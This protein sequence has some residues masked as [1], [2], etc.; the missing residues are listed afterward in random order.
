M[1]AASPAAPLSASTPWTRPRRPGRSNRAGGSPF[2]EFI[3]SGLTGK[4]PNSAKY[5]RYHL[6]SVGTPRHVCT[7]GLGVSKS[8]GMRSSSCL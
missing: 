2:H 6:S 7:V 1:S 5:A 8:T 3:G 4:S